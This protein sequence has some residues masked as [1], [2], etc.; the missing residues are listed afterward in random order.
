MAKRICF[1]ILILLTLILLLHISFRTAENRVLAIGSS[2][3]SITFI[4]RSGNTKELK[5]EKALFVIIYFHLEC[6]H[7]RY[8]LNLINKGFDRFNGTRMFFFTNDKNLFQENKLQKWEKLIVS[9]DVTFGITNRNEFGLGF[10]KLVLP[11][12]FIFN[13]TGELVKKIYGEVKLEKLLK[14]IYLARG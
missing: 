2:P 10:G 13:A 1:L 12:V 14:E 9:E 7:C 6:E 4:D 5:K 8:Q 11:S 3:P